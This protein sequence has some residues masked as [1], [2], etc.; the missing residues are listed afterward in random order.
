MAVF[1]RH[2]NNWCFMIPHWGYFN[3]HQ[4]PLTQLAVGGTSCIVLWPRDGGGGGA[5]GNVIR[6]GAR[7][8]V[9]HSKSYSTNKLGATWHSYILKTQ[10][11]LSAT[12]YAFLRNNCML[13][14]MKSHEIGS[15]S[16][17]SC[18][19]RIL[20]N[21]LKKSVQLLGRKAY[22]VILP[23]VILLV[24]AWGCF[25]WPAICH[26]PLSN[27]RRCGIICDIVSHE[28]IMCKL[29]FHL[30]LFY[31]YSAMSK[32]LL[33]KNTQTHLMNCANPK[34]KHKYFLTAEYVNTS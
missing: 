26:W 23:Y 6:Q 34:W 10:R 9:V 19:D 28:C 2:E 4:K 30:H 1:I 20:Y 24:N 12:L 32:Q 11:S 3:V 27:K 13:F 15:S 5:P 8:V 18:F 21:L 22:S 29:L 31:S 17:K 25:N 14:F 16:S 7:G 33:S